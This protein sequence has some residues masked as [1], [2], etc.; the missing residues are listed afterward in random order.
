VSHWEDE[1]FFI[2]ENHIP[3]LLTTYNPVSLYHL[4]AL[5]AIWVHWCKYFH[6]PENFSYSDRWDWVDTIMVNTRDQVRMRIQESDSAVSWLKIVSERRIQ[7]KDKDPEASVEARAPE[8]EFLL[9]HSQNISTNLE[10]I[11]VGVNSPE[12]IRMWIGTEYLIKLVY[13]EGPCP[14]MKFMYH[15]WEVHTRPPDPYPP[16]YGGEAW[17]IMPRYCLD[18]Y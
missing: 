8:K 15:P 1:Y 18:D 2:E 4:S 10:G 12:E 3:T 17:I 7:I 13:R 14:R 9:V 5:W 16:S 11:K 6:D